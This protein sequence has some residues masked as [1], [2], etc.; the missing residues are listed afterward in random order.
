MATK[1]KGRIGSC[2]PGVR[3]TVCLSILKNYKITSNRSPAPAE[4]R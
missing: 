3:F 1:K 4:S 2:F